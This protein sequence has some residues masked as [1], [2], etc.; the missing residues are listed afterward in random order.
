M[1][2]KNKDNL[3]NRKI[4]FGFFEG[5]KDKKKGVGKEMKK[6]REKKGGIVRVCF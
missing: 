1:A 5:S 4:K 3:T 6:I 2:T